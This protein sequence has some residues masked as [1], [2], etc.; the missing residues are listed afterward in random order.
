MADLTVGLPVFNGERYLAEAVDS[1]LAQTYT[2]FELVI[3]DNASTDDTEAIGRNY[4]ERDE[5]VRYVRHATNLGATGNYNFLAEDADSEYFKWAACDD[6]HAPTH[7]ERCIDALRT[8]PGHV[9]AYSRTMRIDEDGDIMGGER[10]ALRPDAPT[11]H[12]RFRPMVRIQHSCFSIFAVFRRAI[13]CET[14]LL[15]GHRHSDRT[16]LA[17]LA[18]RAPSTEIPEHLLFRRMH[19][20]SFSVGPREGDNAPSSFWM[21]SLRRSSETDEPSLLKLYR[22]ALSDTPLDDDERR[23]CRVDLETAYRTSRAEQWVKRTIVWPVRRRSTARQQTLPPAA[24]GEEEHW[25]AYV[26]DAPG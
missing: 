21:G 1:L 7:L 8:H 5:R 20:G 13:L 24:R 17:E 2:D 3:A 23:R 22:E 9:S 12:E 11:P 18:L 26:D 4:A 14:K 25:T 19:T 16:L 6:V 15:R 10:Y